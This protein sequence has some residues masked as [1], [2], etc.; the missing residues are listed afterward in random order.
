MK[1]VVHENRW[2]LF[3]AGMEIETVVISER[4]T[5]DADLEVFDKVEKYLRL[6]MKIQ[7]YSRTCKNI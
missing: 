3:L 6:F 7:D 5:S 1:C 2:T 4:V